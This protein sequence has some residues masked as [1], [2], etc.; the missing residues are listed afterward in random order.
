MNEEYLRSNGTTALCD[1][2]C[3]YFKKSLLILHQA[4]MINVTSLA[5]QRQANI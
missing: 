2:Y 5:V 4:E 3:K 1:V